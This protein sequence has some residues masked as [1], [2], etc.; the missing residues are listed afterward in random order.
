MLH[1]VAADI[2]RPNVTVA[3][4]R[5]VLLLLNAW[6]VLL[7]PAASMLSPHCCCY[8]CRR[9]LP[10]IVLQH[11]Q[12]LKTQMFTAGALGSS[13]H[14]L[15]VGIVAAELFDSSYSLYHLHRM[16]SSHQQSDW[17]AY[18]TSCSPWRDCPENT[19]QHTSSASIGLL[20]PSNRQSICFAP[21]AQK[22]HQL[23]KWV[24]GKYYCTMIYSYLCNISRCSWSDLL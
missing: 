11:T 5:P 6:Y 10:R 1:A 3:V 2:V 16:R 14:L 21:W 15:C 13:S 24:I 7:P 20:S 19:T 22:K 18:C 8:C 23:V 17:S 4:V 12:P 9:S